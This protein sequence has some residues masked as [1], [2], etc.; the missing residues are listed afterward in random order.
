MDHFDN[1]AG[2]RALWNVTT[3]VAGGVEYP[4]NA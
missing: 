2:Q 4:A 3:R 1:P